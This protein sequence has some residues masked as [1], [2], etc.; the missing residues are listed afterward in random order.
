MKRTSNAKAFPTLNVILPC[1][2]ILKES[3]EGGTVSV[4]KYTVLYMGSN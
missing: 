1:K 3:T 4:G 2:F